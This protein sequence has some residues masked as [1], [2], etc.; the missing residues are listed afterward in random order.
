MCELSEHIVL[1]ITENNFTKTYRIA[2]NMHKSWAWKETESRK[3]F[4]S[5]LR[6]GIVKDEGLAMSL[7][8]Y[9]AFFTEV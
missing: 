9:K 3:Y 8:S 7:F 1:T 6:M 4:R 5:F 2:Q